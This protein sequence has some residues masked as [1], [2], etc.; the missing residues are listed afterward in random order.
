MIDFEKEIAKYGNS[1]SEM[2]KEAA[3]NAFND[4]LSRGFTFEWLYY[5]VQRLGGRSVLTHPNL[6]FYRPF[7]EEVNAML[8][9]AREEESKKKARNTE[10]CA[11]IEAQILLMHSKPVKVIRQPPKPKKVKEIDLAAIANMEDDVDGANPK[12]ERIGAIEKTD[13]K[14]DL[15][16]RVRGL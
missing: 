13:S 6:M 3:R 10:I 4:L 16:R 12:N 1:L 15:L 8:E 2:E 14:I 11:K 9:A 7:Q 5:A